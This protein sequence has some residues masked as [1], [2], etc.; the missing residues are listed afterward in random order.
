MKITIANEVI[1]TGEQKMVNIQKI[2][3]EEM[4]RFRV[5]NERVHRSNNI[6]ILFEK[7]E[8]W[9]HMG[10]TPDGR[11][12]INRGNVMVTCQNSEI[13]DIFESVEF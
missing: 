11:I 5:I 3:G 6:E 9:N 10:T 1:T 13:D 2:R 12:I 4:K 7:G 8:I